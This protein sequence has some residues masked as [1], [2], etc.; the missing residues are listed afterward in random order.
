MHL[1]DPVATIAAA[2][3]DAA[4][5]RFKDIVYQDRDWGQYKAAKLADPT[6]ELDS[7]E[8]MVV[9]TRR[10]NIDDCTVVAMF[11]QS[12]SSTAL[13][14]GGLG[15]QAITPAYTVV[16]ECHDEYAVYFGKRFAYLINRPN[17][18]FYDHL[19]NCNMVRCSEKSIYHQ[20]CETSNNAD[21]R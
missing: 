5:F 21:L 17:S 12:W 7:S 8:F 9:K 1:T 13:G 4:D 2:C 3:Y 18:I 10:P 11:P 16:V 19:A 20:Q 15:G 6:R 14:F